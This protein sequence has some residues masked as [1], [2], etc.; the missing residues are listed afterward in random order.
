MPNVSNSMQILYEQGGPWPTLAST[1][2]RPWWY[3]RA[4][5]PPRL[6]RR[7]PTCCFAR[8]PRGPADSFGALANG[9]WRPVVGWMRS[10]FKD[11]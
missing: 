6:G 5:R 8:P 2:L 1:K 11:H 4:L 10:C 3:V 7:R 9:V